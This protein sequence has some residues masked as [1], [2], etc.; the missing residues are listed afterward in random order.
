MP[1]DWERCALETSQ[2]V[3]EGGAVKICNGNSEQSP[4]PFSL[5][6]YTIIVM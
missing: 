2:R 5:K 6:Y 3:L 4:Y 1:M